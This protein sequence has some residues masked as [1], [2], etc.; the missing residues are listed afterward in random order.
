[1]KKINID[2][3]EPYY[4]YII[5]GKK[6]VEGRINK[7]KFAILNKGDIILLG[8]EEIQFRVIK[9]TIYNTFEQMI[10][11]EGIE[12]VIPDKKDVKDAI[13]V[14]YTFYTRKQEKEFGVVAIKIKQLETNV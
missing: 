1:M 4:S 8:K 2:V 13:N 11:S 6:T 12:N 3:Q 7:G 10:N 5:S 14:Y 9:K